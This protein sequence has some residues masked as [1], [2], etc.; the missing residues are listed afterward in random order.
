MSNKTVFNKQLAAPFD[1]RPKTKGAHF[2][3]L[4]MTDFVDLDA[5]F[6]CNTCKSCFATTEKIKEHYRGE[7]HILNSKRRANG[8][9]PLK[10]SEFKA[11]SKE[12]SGSRKS[13]QGSVMGE[14][15]PDAVEI[16]KSETIFEEG[17]NAEEAGPAEVVITEEAEPEPPVIAANISIFDDK[18]FATT[19]ECVQYMA[20]TFGFFIP[21]VEFLVDLE[22]LL[23]YL[24]EKVKLGGYCLYCQ[25]LFV[26]GKP[27]QNHMVSKSHCKLRYENGIDGEEFEDFYD[28]SSSYEDMEDVEFDEDGNVIEGGM[29]IASTGEMVLADGRILG[30]RDFRQYYKQ[31][32][33]PQDTREP[34]L[35]Q[36][37]EELLRLGGKYGGL[38]FNAEEV[39]QLEDM[40]VMTMLVKYHKDIRRGQIVEQRSQQ[41]KDF[42]NQRLEYN[43]KNQKARTSEITTQKIRD[44]HGMLK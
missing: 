3:T 17:E 10:R 33:R 32:Y 28:F 18:E 2:I 13:T 7:W 23:V 25:K 30:H 21:D 4:T 15:A 8:L 44:Y 43:N 29:T 42:R 38:K 39:D 6:K 37:R 1:P 19:D 9:F 34:I 5:T 41:K 14:K 20:E 40:Q 26:P 35:A 27:C 22:G 16:S 24:G 11:I 36:Q 31:Y 12:G